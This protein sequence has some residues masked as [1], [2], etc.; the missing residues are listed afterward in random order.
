LGGVLKRG[1]SGGEKKRVNV[2]LA[3]LAN[4]SLLLLDEPTSGLDL[5]TAEKLLETLKRLA[6]TGLTVVTTIHQPSSQ[7]Y[8]YFDKLVLMMDG[9]MVYHGAASNALNYFNDLGL[10]CDKYYN[11]ADFMMGMILQQQGEDSQ[12]LKSM[13]IEDY[14][15]YEKKNKKKIA[16]RVK[17][18]LKDYN[19][20]KTD[21]TKKKYPTSWWHQFSVIFKREFIEKKGQTL[22]PLMFIQIFLVSIIAGLLWFQ[23]PKQED[24]INDVLGSMFFGLIFIGGFFPFLQAVLTFGQTRAVLIKERNEGLY[25]L[26]AFFMAKVLADIPFE[27][28]FPVIFTTIIYWLTDARRDAGAYFLYLI[29]ILFGSFASSGFGL[30]FSS[31]IP[32]FKDAMVYGSVALLSIMLTSG[33]YVDLQLMPS[34]IRWTQYISHLKYAYDGLLVTVFRGA[35]FNQIDGFSSPFEPAAIIT[36]TTVNGTLVLNTFEPPIDGQ[37]VLD[38]EDLA[39]DNIWGNIIVL[40]G[41]AVFFRIV[42]YI[43]LKLRY[44]PKK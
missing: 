3:L 5:G 37:R 23:I 26:S 35:T 39:I 34:W 15:A 10:P 36:N 14:Q 22:E 20:R 32:V 4:P 25:R 9:H 7:M 27:M 42:A 38:R 33:F 1:V 8:K 31:W 18:E 11:P 21:L 6:E 24:R 40:F 43:G 12:E 44:K 30:M 17:K 16:K 41:F 2:A 13:L 29:V 19:K 28:I